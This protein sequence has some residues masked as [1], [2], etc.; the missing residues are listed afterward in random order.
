M[1]IAGPVTS[2]S[3]HSMIFLCYYCSIMNDPIN[4]QRSMIISEYTQK[5]PLLYLNSPNSSKQLARVSSF[6][7][8]SIVS[9]FNHYHQHLKKFDCYWYFVHD[10]LPHLLVS[11]Y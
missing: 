11:D 9:S 5:Q 3:R 4:L 1:T 10:A 8:C 2:K 6:T 7:F